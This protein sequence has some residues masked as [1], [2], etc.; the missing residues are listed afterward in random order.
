M[1][2]TEHFTLPLLECGTCCRSFLHGSVEVFRAECPHCGAH[3]LPS[4][5]D[6]V[7]KS[8]EQLIWQ[9]NTVTSPLRARIISGNYT[10]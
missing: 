2:S 8:V 10:I 3:Y 6:S 1:A 4:C 9:R 7:G 5:I